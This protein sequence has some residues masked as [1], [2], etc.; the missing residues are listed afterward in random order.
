ND[1][2]NLIEAQIDSNSTTLI[3]FNNTLFSVPS[4]YEVSYL[5]KRE[6]IE[7]NKEIL[8]PTNRSHNYTNNF[9]KALNMGVYGADLGYLNIYQQTPE[10]VNYFSTV[11]I[12]AQELNMSNAFDKKTI[13]S[14]ENNMGN[15]DSLMFI[16]SNTYRRADEYLKD[17]GREDDGVL[18]LAGGWIESLYILVEIADLD[19]NTE[20]IIRIGEQKHPL[21]NLI[22]ILSPFYN[23]SAEFSELID[24]LIDLAY[25]FDGID[26]HYTYEEP[27][28]DVANKLT[29][30]NSKS[31]LVM[32]DQQ[33]KI[34]SEKVSDIR[35]FIV[36]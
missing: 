3:K 25:E 31:E 28:I 2:N 6:S 33:L 34:I 11:K 8:N 26:I 1:I 36:E 12:L 35:K 13:Q 4:P 15:T 27:T 32:T 7:Y 21:D 29:T 17:N 14:I 20:V 30:I 18:I 10:A 23:N 19:K 16:I 5:I 24:M 9:K 22:K